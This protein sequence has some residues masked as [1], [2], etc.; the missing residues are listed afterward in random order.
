MV[1]GALYALLQVTGSDV[2]EIVNLFRILINEVGVGLLAI[3][4]LIGAFKDQSLHNH[5]RMAMVIAM[6][7][8]LIFIH[9]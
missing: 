8:V 4:M 9:Y 3:G 1:A 7:L 6:A 5:V 2:Y